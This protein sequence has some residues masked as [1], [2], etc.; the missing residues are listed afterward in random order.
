M[1]P[2]AWRRNGAIRIGAGLFGFVLMGLFGTKHPAVAAYALT[3]AVGVFLSI[4]LEQR[5]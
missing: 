5:P 2:A 4:A 3:Y 1:T